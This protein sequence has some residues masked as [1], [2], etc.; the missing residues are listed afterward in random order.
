MKRHKQNVDLVVDLCVHAE[1]S[2]QRNL[3]LSEELFSEIDK[4]CYWK[5]RQM[6]V[7]EFRNAIR[8]MID[9]ET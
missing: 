1:T 6:F 2:V 8:S 5:L 4:A 9:E 7:N 3:L